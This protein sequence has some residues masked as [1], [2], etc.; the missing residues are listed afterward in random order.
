MRTTIRLQDELLDAAKRRAAET[1]R[2]LTRFIEDV[3]R[4]ALAQRS[5]RSSPQSRFE[6]R[7][8]EGRGLRPGI[9]LDSNAALLDVMEDR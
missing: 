2:T 9:D 7:P 6:V 3:L 8:F 1:G 5:L 4:E